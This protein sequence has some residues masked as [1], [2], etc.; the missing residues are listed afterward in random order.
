MP[1]Y[2]F[3]FITVKANLMHLKNLGHRMLH[4]IFKGKNFRCKLFVNILVGMTA[5]FAVSQ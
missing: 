5:I 2:C 4:N 1:Q 3:F